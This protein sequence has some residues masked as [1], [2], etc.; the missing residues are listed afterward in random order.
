M[1]LNIDHCHQARLARDH[2]FDGRFF[3][4]VKTTGIYCR[5]VCPAPPPKE[6]NVEYFEH[7]AAAA[8]A[9]YRP[10]LRCRPETAPLSP[11]W[12]GTQTTVKR[13]LALIHA[14]ELTSG[15]AEFSERLGVSDRHLRRLFLEHVGVAPLAYALNH[16]L[17]FAKQLLA[18]TT[19]PVLDVAFAS[20]F[21]SR[22]RFN[23]AFISQFSLTPSDIRRGSGETGPTLKLKLNYRPPLDWEAMLAFLRLR[24][25]AGV[26]WVEGSKYGRTIDWLGVRG[27]FEVEPDATK[28]LL[29][30][31]LSWS[32][33]KTLL[34]V[35]QR[36]RQMFDLDFDPQALDHLSRCPH[37]DKT[38]QNHPGLRIAGIWSEFEA[39]VRGLVGQ[40]ISV[41]AARTILGRLAQCY[42]HSEVGGRESETASC[43]RWFPT[44]AQLSQQDLA[45]LGLTKTRA[46]WLDGIASEYA[47]GFGAGEG[48]LEQRVKRLCQLTGVGDWTANYVCMRALRE[49]DAFPASDLGLYHGLQLEKGTPAQTLR[50]A[51]E[52]RP[53][54][55]YGVMALW[56]SLASTPT[57]E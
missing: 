20:G 15:I 30:L 26:E 35:M 25:V 48:D 46:A 3:T 51:Q 39:V 55:S 22:R 40:Q 19:L 50:V 42:G 57:N 29:H 36:I 34:S 12:Q 6:A 18:E 14:G 56:H 53:W 23:D 11:A 5:P 13:A 38:I 44:P 10:C 2:R 32:E 43:R 54:R 47:N 17:L 28:P 24:A 4:A 37:L 8:E 21:Q 49:T 9:G 31:T 52:W 1:K 16:R 41:S 45:G 7:A 33:P 27:W